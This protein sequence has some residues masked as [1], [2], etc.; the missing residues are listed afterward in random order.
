MEGPSELPR[1]SYPKILANLAGVLAV[2]AL[3]GLAMWQGGRRRPEPVP[4]PQPEP[5]V[6]AAEP[7]EVVE[8]PAVVA[9]PTPPE[10]EPPKVD[11]EAV[12]RAEGSVD[13]ASRDRA[14]AEGRAA[15][16]ARELADASARA[17]AAAKA[18]KT[19]AYRV[20]DPS[21]RIASAASRGGFLKA[22]RD[23]LQ[24]EVAAIDWA[25]R[26]KAKVLSNKN[27]VARPSDGQEYHF[28]VRRDRVTFIDL[29]R[30]L[31]KVKLD[32][33]LRI[34]LTDGAR[35]V[36]SRVG[37][38]GAFSLQYSLVRGVPAGLDE[39]IERRGLAYELRAWEAV[40]EFEGRGETYDAA[41][42]PISEF[43]RVLSRMNPARETVTLW[44]YPDGFDLFRKLRDALHQ[45][46]FVVAARPL[47]EGMP[48]RGSPSGSLSAG[49]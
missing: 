45:R 20:K 15:A 43:S 31:D 2:L 44:I 40:P 9:A 36:D 33:R 11:A 27:P 12:A 41:L 42:R 46:G 10:P 34:R 22:E 21:A 4:P 8:P 7:E 5:V 17:A 18:A 13:A 29:T 30:L 47:P 23:R 24:G 28:E 25:P 38:I 26:P 48:V 37:P 16:A 49:Q 3:M 35:V 1:E 6:A 14:R 32:A 19:L 39:L